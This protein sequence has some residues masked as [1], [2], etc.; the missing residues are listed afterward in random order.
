M[1]PNNNCFM[2]FFNKYS[3]YAAIIIPM[4]NIFDIF[5][6]MFDKFFVTLH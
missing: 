1:P 3:P 5:D 4:R 6:K 2:N